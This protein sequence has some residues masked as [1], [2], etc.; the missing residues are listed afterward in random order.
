MDAKDIGLSI[1]SIVLGLGGAVAGV[2]GGPAAA[3]GVAKADKGLDRLIGIDPPA[4]KAARG[5]R[6]DRADYGARPPAQPAASRAPTTAERP[7][8]ALRSAEAP[9]AAREASDPPLGD[10]QITTDFLQAR[11]WS[12]EKVQGIL[13]GPQAERESGA[14]PD[15]FRTFEVYGV[16]SGTVVPLLNV[17]ERKEGGWQVKPGAQVRATDRATVGMGLAGVPGRW[18]EF[19]PKHPPE[20]Y[21]LNAGK[22]VLY[23]EPQRGRALAAS[24]GLLSQ[25]F[26]RNWRSTVYRMEEDHG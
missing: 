13:D 19:Y 8:P 24:A 23:W 17:L 12:A 5:E 21:G 7:A 11:G 15:A 20:E 10:E 14:E 4:E 1:K 3:E 22:A 25:L 26:G 6:F 16:Q 2:A 9:P 18:S